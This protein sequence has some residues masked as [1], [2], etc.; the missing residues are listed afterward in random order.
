VID[1]DSFLAGIQRGEGRLSR[2][3]ASLGG[4][5]IPAHRLL[6]VQRHAETVIVHRTHLPLCP[7]VA[8]LRSL[9]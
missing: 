6:V 9:A 1:G 7:D 8:L 2:G 3:V 5:V 4:L